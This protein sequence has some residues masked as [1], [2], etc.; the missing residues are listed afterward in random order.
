[1]WTGAPPAWTD[2]ARERDACDSGRTSVRQIKK[3][4]MLRCDDPLHHYILWFSA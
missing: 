2:E 4:Y 3:H 1:M